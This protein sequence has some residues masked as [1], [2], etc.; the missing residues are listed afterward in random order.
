MDSS[1]SNV[2]DTCGVSSVISETITNN[3][4]LENCVHQTFPSC[5]REEQWLQNLSEN[6][7]VMMQTENLVADMP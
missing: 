5:W 7:W 1:V 3:S 6:E 2:S 4:S